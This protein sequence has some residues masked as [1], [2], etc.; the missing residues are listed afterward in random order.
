MSTVT[1][2]WGFLNFM[3]YHLNFDIEPIV[4][5]I[6]GVYY[7]E[8]W[9][10]VKGYEGFYGVSTFGRFYSMRDNKIMRQHINA[11]GYLTIAIGGAKKRKGYKCH[12]LVG[13]AFIDNPDNKPEI[14]HDDFD[15]L[16]NF[17][18]NLHWATTQ[19]NT[20]HY[21]RSQPAPKPPK[22][23]VG[24]H[25][26]KCQKIVDTSTGEIFGTVFQLAEETG[27]TPKYLR[28][29]LSGEARNHTNYKWL[30][31]QWTLFYKK[32]HDAAVNRFNELRPRIY[33]VAI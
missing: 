8:E 19:E 6:K 13:L 10:D 17:Y 16:N 27:Y 25:P 24:E 1:T 31:G 3:R 14:N 12:R 4:E 28:K 23:K 29:M 18:K 21:W 7:T 11:N 33:G 5:E 2:C 30:K 22:E 20:A 9:K 15:K 32:R 26:I